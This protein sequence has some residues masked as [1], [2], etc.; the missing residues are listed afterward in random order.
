MNAV[1]S[2]V[3]LIT[4]TPASLALFI[5]L[6]EDSGNWSNM[7][8]LDISAAE[9]GNLTDLKKH[10]LLHTDRDEGIDWVIFDFAAGTRVTDGDN[11]FD[12]VKHLRHSE[13]LPV[14]A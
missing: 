9:R 11:T 14:A 5:A 3:T 1:V 10:G 12:L 4:L 2:P 6:V 8:M 7:P 13:A